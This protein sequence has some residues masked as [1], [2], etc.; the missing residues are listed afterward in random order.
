M[1]RSKFVWLIVFETGKTQFFKS[2][3]LR[4]IID[5]EY[6]K[7]D[8]DAIISSTKMELADRYNYEDAVDIP[9]VD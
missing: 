7:E 2:Q 4:Q 8:S 6:L 5:S 3:T 9:F 1:A